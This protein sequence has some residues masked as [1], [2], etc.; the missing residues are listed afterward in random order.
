MLTIGQ[1][2]L[3]L[4]LPVVTSDGKAQR[5]AIVMTV[6]STKDITRLLAAWSAGDQAALERLTPLVHQELHRLARAYMSREN[7]AHT[8]QATAL[9]NEA[10]L[11]LIDSSRVQWQNRTHFFALSA[12]LMRHILVDFA[13]SRQSLKSGGEAH[14]VSFDERMPFSAQSEEDLVALDEALKDLARVEPRQ[15]Q[16]IELRFFGGLS[17]KETAEALRISVASVRRDWALAR[18]WLRRR[19]T[20]ETQA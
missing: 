8:L 4:R 5:V 9:V 11:R 14:W 1:K 3:R 13:R 2:I 15:S 19:F 10:Y 20:P 6:P 17:L 12:R 7:P 16:V 18:A